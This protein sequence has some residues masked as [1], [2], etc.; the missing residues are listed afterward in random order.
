MSLDLR[1][2]HEKLLSDTTYF[3]AVASAKWITPLGNATRLLAR[4]DLGAT[5]TQDFSA[6]PATARFFTGGDTTVRG[7]GFETIGPVDEQGNV[8]GGKHLAVFSLEA[9]WLIAGNWAVAAFIDSGSSFNDTDVDFK[10]GVGLGVHWY[11]PF[12]PVRLDVGHPLDNPDENY[13]LHIT[14][15]PDL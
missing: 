11:S 7:Y 3:Q 15:G 6:L 12:G 2:A 1:G 9:D 4:T 5:V 8:T 10:T 13:R 14:F